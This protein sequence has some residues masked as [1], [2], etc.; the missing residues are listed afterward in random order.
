MRFAGAA[1]KIIRGVVNSFDTFLF[2]HFWL[3]HNKWSFGN[4]TTLENLGGYI[5]LPSQLDH[6]GKM[7]KE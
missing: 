2:S 6:P 7:D 5:E 3:L 4:R 1:R